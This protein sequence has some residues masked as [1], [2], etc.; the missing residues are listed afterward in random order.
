MTE[1]QKFN[2][3]KLISEYSVIETVNVP[4]EAMAKI[5]V[6]KGDLVEI[7]VLEDDVIVIRKTIDPV[8]EYR[9]NEGLINENSD[10]E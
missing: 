2:Y 7:E 4:V 3:N 10:I 9:M 5:G 1:V 6:F 8:K